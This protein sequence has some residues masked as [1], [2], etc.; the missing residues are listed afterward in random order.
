M[1]TVTTTIR[2]NSA[3]A[4]GEFNKL[5]GSLT[6]ATALG[7]VFGNALTGAFEMAVGG[8]QSL[9]SAFGEASS[10]QLSMIGAA[11]DLSRITGLSF[12]D[13]KADLQDFSNEM[14]RMAATLPGTSSDFIA[15]GVAMS[16]SLGKGL[17]MDDGSLDTA[18]F[19]KYREELSTFAG[20]RT[21]FSGV[22]VEDTN[23]FL[24]K[25]M[26]GKS[27]AEL[28]TLKFAEQN[29]GVVSA[30]EQ[31]LQE[32]GRELKDMSGRELIEMAHEVMRVEQEVMDAASLSIDGL[33][34]SFK[35]GLF[36]PTTGIF[37][38]ERDLNPLV[39]GNQSVFA[40][41]TRVIQKSL[42]DDGLLSKASQLLGDAGLD[43]DPMQMLADGLGRVGTWIDRA[44]DW[45]GGFD[46]L[47]LGEFDV[48]ALGDVAAKGAAWLGDQMNNFFQKIGD[49]DAT[50]IGQQLGRGIALAIDAVSAYMSNLDFAA[51]GKGF[52]N[53]GKAMAVA[54]GS[55]I[56][57]IDWGQVGQ[58][59][60]NMG[61][62]SILGLA[63]RVVEAFGRLGATVSGSIINAS[64]WAVE[65]IKGIGAQISGWIASIG[66]AFADA[67]ADAKAR[68]AGMFNI[69]SQGDDDS[70][71]GFSGRRVGN[72]ATGLDQMGLFAAIA[73]EQ[74][75]AP[76]R[77][78]VVANDS[79]LIVPPAEQ[80]SLLAALNNKAAAQTGP[81]RT[82]AGSTVFNLG[83][84]H[85]SGEVANPKTLA[86]QVMREINL[87]YQK[88]SI[89]QAALN[90]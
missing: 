19:E 76:G 72:K 49:M 73:R 84:I 53:I 40:N 90:Y 83:G 88:H 7:T 44:N 30:I 39:E 20:M 27:L 57:S 17:K 15:L 41:F 26:D 28:K 36:S 22:M 69:F 9:V 48:G 3:D 47:N 12:A 16:D 5:G 45:L 25:L 21:E 42:G 89:S 79:E 6:K 23:L 68:I 50:K 18:A 59:L 60:S 58:A 38:I 70:P 67:F 85:I 29:V 74:S 14:A 13:S 52:L 65:S 33:V 71:M 2:V 8:A 62:I 61:Q 11:G 51:I 77:N 54:L 75:A 43:I 86:K 56:I 34:A 35:D 63:A 4:I 55:A 31:N 10:K 32:T 80:R 1:N 78:I 46:S 64:A 24:S 81:V 66:R 87:E 82:Q 37:G